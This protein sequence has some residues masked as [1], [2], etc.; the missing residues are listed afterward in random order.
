[1]TE[2]EII[3]KS[4]EIT[5]MLQQES[6]KKLNEAQA[7]HKGYVQACEDYGRALRLEVYEQNENIREKGTMK[8]SEFANEVATMLEA[9][10]DIFKE[11][12]KAEDYDGIRDEIFEYCSNCD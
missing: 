8:A 6:S 12:L 10:S 5:D 1:M 9:E 2:Q 4:N 7:Y 11:L 3:N